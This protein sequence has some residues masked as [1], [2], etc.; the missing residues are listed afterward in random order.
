[1]IIGLLAGF[2]MGFI[3]IGA[4]ILLIF[5]LIRYKINLSSLMATL[6][7]MIAF[8]CLLGSII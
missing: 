3:G 2:L 8:S 7:L 5:V 4:S 6:P 1:M